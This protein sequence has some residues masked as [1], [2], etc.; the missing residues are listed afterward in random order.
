MFEPF[1]I[2]TAVSMLTLRK[3]GLCL[4]S[5]AIAEFHPEINTEG[6]VDDT[7][8]MTFPEFGH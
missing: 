6:E 7:L 3:K 1:L 4:Y 5:S 8:I 2:A